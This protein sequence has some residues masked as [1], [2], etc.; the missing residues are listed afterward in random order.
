MFAFVYG[1]M[2][3]LVDTC[4]C[5]SKWTRDHLVQLWGHSSNPIV[6]SPPCNTEVLAALDTVERQPWVLSV[7]QFREEKD[8]ALQLR[9]FKALLDKGGWR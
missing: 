5:N 2:G 1:L 4:M 6:V 3:R 7:G 9:S 8:H